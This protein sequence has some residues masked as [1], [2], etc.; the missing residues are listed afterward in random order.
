MFTLQKTTLKSETAS[1]THQD[2]Y[3]VIHNETSLK[4]RPAT[5]L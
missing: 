2:I 3:K 1:P 4:A 5:Y